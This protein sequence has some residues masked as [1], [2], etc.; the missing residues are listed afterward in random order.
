[1]RIH[2]QQL[3]SHHVYGADVFLGAG[4]VHSSW[5][6]A[7]QLHPHHAS[8]GSKPSASTR[9][10]LQETEVILAVRRGISSLRSS[11]A[12]S[13]DRLQEI[14]I[15]D[16]VLHP[17]GP[18]DYRDEPAPLSVAHKV[19]EKMRHFVGIRVGAWD[20]D[21]IV[22]TFMRPNTYDD[23]LYLEVV[24]RVLAPIM[25]PYRL[26]VQWSPRG[27]NRFAALDIPSDIRR[28]LPVNCALWLRSSAM[29]VAPWKRSS[30]G[31]NL[32][33]EFSLRQAAA[34]PEHA[35]FFQRLDAERYIKTV[36]LRIFSAI[37]ELLQSKG[38]SATEF[39]EAAA[40]VVNAGIMITGGNFAG[41]NFS[42]GDHSQQSTR[43]TAST[44]G[45]PAEASTP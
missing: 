15:T 16:H 39:A 43:T 4:S 5:S 32:D 24:V 40:Q 18:S 10:M 33:P 1:M 26:P 42:V 30:P 34:A 38:L 17:P 8:D 44:P 36:E 20:E 14:F 29:A 37:K 21:L 2:N 3:K 11:I 23:I 25:A 19:D 35:H 6:F 13:G 9:P 41:D 7:T 45:T 27:V 28:A 22:T 31:K 12:L